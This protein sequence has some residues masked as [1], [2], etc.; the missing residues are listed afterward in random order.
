MIYFNDKE[1]NLKFNNVTFSRVMYNNKKI[2]PSN[3]GINPANQATLYP[4]PAN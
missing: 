3:S 2:Y 1:I 4:T